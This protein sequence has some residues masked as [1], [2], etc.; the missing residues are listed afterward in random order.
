[1]GWAACWALVRHLVHDEQLHVADRAAG[2]LLLLFAQPVG[3][4]SR[5]TTEHI[6]YP[7]QP[8]GLH[9]LGRRL[10]AIGVPP[11]LARHASLMVIASELPAVVISRLLGFHQSTCDIRPARVRASLPS[12][13]QTSSGGE[14]SPS[15]GMRRHRR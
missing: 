9:T 1:M 13:P 11:Q 10:K 2:L 8:I 7:G 5:L 4:I 15:P 6:I 14:Q 3:R 12:T